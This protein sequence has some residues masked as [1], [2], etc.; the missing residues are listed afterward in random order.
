[1]LEANTGWISRR[2]ADGAYRRVCW[3]PYERRDRGVI[4]CWGERVCVGTAS[5]MVTI[6]DFSNFMTKHKSAFVSELAL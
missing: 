1:M 3:L 5:G 6:L 4:A 2:R